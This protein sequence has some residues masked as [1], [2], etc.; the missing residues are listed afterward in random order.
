MKDKVYSPVFP[1]CVVVA[2]AYLL[3]AIFLSVFSFAANTILHCF[4]VDTEIQGGRAPQ[5]L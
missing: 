1:V 3:S 4:V 5:S 2:I